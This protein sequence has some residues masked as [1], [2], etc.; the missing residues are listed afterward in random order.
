MHIW[1]KI[2][3]VLSYSTTTPRML[4]WVHILSFILAVG[5]G[6]F[7]SV[8]FRH[9]DEKT[10]RRL[11]LIAS[12]ISIVLEI[13]KQFVFSF[14]YDGQAVKFDYQWYAFPFQFCSMPMYVGLLA[15][16]IK[17]GRL[18]DAL[19]AF[20]ATYGFF[21]GLVV[22]VYPVQVYI[23]IIGINAQTM[24]CHGLMVAMGIYFLACGYVKLKHKTMLMALSVFSSLVGLVMILNEAVFYSGILNGETLNMFYISRHFSPSLP[25]YSLIQAIVPYPFCVIFYVFGFSAAAYIILL[26]AMGINRIISNVKNRKKVMA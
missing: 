14:S 23:G 6:V 12:V 21:G 9:S 16:F 5:F 19:C 8:R 10:V 26:C 22:M 4:G 20:L 3:D 11:L 2:I 18:H 25:V 24:I 15:A 17:R 7:L 13:Y 1:G